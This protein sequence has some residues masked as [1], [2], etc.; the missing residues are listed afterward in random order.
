MIWIYSK[1]THK[2]G[3]K[4][5]EPYY[6]DITSRITE[7]NKAI[8]HN[9]VEGDVA[10]S[11]RNAM[12][13]SNGSCKWPKSS[14]GLVEVPY[15]FSDY[16]YD[17]E[18]ASIKEAMDTFH[19]KTYV[20]F[21][22]HRGQSD[23][24]SIEREMGRGD[25]CWATIGRDGGRQ[26]VSLFLYGCLDRGTIQ[27]ELLHTLGFHHE[28]TRSERDRYVRINWQNVPS[29]NHANHFNKM[30][31]SYDYSSVMH[32]GRSFF[33]SSFGADT[34]APIPDSSVPIG[35]RNGMS[36]LDILRINRLYKCNV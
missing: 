33:A 6:L 32:Y 11:K 8:S 30:N 15:I 22:P 16:F 21:V 12:K 14:S 26:L 4:V 7:A 10:P 3:L 18:K 28:H 29:V 31:M 36:Y 25:W 24:L 34:I 17:G 19:K 27:H 35:Q 9:L 2:E 13:C 23:Y 20:R 1:C 5:E